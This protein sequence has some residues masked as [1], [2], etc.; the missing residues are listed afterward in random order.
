MTAKTTLIVIKCQYLDYV[1]GK[2]CWMAYQR[3]RKQS[4][5][6]VSFCPEAGVCQHSISLCNIISTLL[7]KNWAV[8]LMCLMFG[9]VVFFYKAVWWTVKTEINMASTI[10]CYVNMQYKMQFDIGFEF[11]TFQVQILVLV[12]FF[13]CSLG[14]KTNGC[15]YSGWYSFAS[16]H[17]Q[18]LLSRR[19]YTLVSV[20]FNFCLLICAAYLAPRS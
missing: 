10:F 15:T 6:C 2:N 17:F 14:P 16:D 5:R 11:Y 8:C 7:Y 3:Y 9:L 1:R 13:C 4:S 12:T 18:L 19:C 20:P